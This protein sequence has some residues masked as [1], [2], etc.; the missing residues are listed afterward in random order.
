V[1]LGLWYDLYFIVLFSS[2][3]WMQ[4][5]LAFGQQWSL[6]RVAGSLGGFGVLKD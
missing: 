4:L 3:S 1:E 2:W 6:V 5:T